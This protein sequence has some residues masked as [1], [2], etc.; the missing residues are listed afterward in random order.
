MIRAAVRRP[1]ATAMVFLGLVLIGAV[2]LG[3]I[4][5]DLL[6]E[7]NYPRLTA[8]TQY[9]DIQAE[10]VERLVTVPLEAAV[11]SLPSVRRVES[12]SREGL[13]V[14]TIEYEWGT[15]MDFAGLHLREA[16]DRVAFRTDFPEQ[17][18]RP[19]ILRWDPTSRPISILVLRGDKPLRE[20][21][22]FATE[23]AK[24]ALEQIQG[25]SQ[26]E[27]V[28]GLD[29]EI[30]IEPDPEK[31]RI[32]NLTI[33]DIV[34]ALQASNVSFPGGQVRSGPLHLSLRIIGEFEDL[35]QIAETAIER[36]GGRALRIG[37][38]AEVI[39]GVQEP[40]G[41]TILEGQDVV[42]FLLYK[43]IGA[44][45]IDV[46]DEIATVLALLEKQYPDFDYRFIYRDA[47]FIR[48]SFT[49]LLQSLLFGAFLAF[50]ILFLFLRDWRSPIVIGI[51]IPVSIMVT[52]AFLYL[53]NVKMNLMSLGG[54]SLAA[55]MLVDNAIVVLEN[56]TRHIQESA[57]Q[58]AHRVAPP[59]GSAAI[60]MGARGH[61][62]RGAGE[63]GG[64]VSAATLTTVAVFFPVVYVP[65]V[66]GEFF[67]DQALTVT[68]SLLVSVAAALLLQ[69]TLAARLLT[70]K[71][72]EPRGPF[73]LFARALSAVYRVYHGALEHALDH[74]TVWVIGLL[75]LL[76][77]SALVAWELPR[78]FL[79]ARS[80]GDLS[81]DIELPAGTPLEETK[82]T[83]V[84]IAERLEGLD[85][86]QTVFLEVGTTER[87]LA[88]VKEYT[89][90]HTAEIR[91]I[92]HPEHAGQREVEALKDR[93][94]SYLERFP[95]V[96]H[97]FRDEGIGLREIIGS[98]GAPFSLGILAEEA[99]TAVAAAAE[100]RAAISDVEG[101]VDLEVDRVLGTPNLVLR[102]DREEAIR[103]G[104]DPEFLARELRNRI[105]GVA[106]TT[107]NE[108]EQRV[109][110]AV[111]FPDA[112][113]KDLEG[114]LGTPVEVGPGRLVRLGRF[115]TLTEET[116][117]RE[118]VR[119][120]QRRL[121]TITG[122]VRGRRA[123]HVRRDAL[124]IAR[125][126]DLPPDVRF[127]EGGEQEEVRASFRELGF[128]LLLA[129][130][131]VYMILAGMFESFVDPLL[132]ASVLPMG[133]AGAALTLGIFGQSVNILSMIGLVALI[134][135]SV[136]DA[137]VKIHTIRR[138][139]TDEGYELR[140][141]VLEGS[142]LRFR[143][144][145]MTSVT[146][147]V[148]MVPMAIGLGSG[149]QLQRPLALTIIGGLALATVL[150]LIFTP[151]LYEWIHGR[152]E[153]R[154]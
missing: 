19:L 79:P 86:V 42:S 61:A 74:K 149:E 144:I 95:S 81:L 37:E 114:I 5:V 124:R 103:S 138:L 53:A 96:L 7:I 43:E 136:N 142:R 62:V 104:L 120:D 3:R 18:E 57:G 47:E 11:T 78:S 130:L 12:R 87:T 140:A 25:L 129:I 15:D 72:L 1:V 97:A 153:P 154:V 21:T 83:C 66:A 116:P 132:I 36:P 94:T 64:A 99:E 13:S 48:A 131:I 54:L 28:G 84:R 30:R 88:A 40:E 77:G 143:P 91:V 139:R 89:A 23:V 45:T 68:F 118:L 46:S 14:I 126:L 55:G 75:I 16:L 148:G 59:A 112:E 107:F 125:G 117:V 93:M 31:M 85:P 111:R 115:V 29:R 26:A 63:V 100:V 101:L 56:I 102:I 106:A 123:D 135:I 38:V 147:V 69:P 24:P 41:A 127:L 35:A 50:F 71:V 58:R 98:S 105:Q 67:R 92:L 113:R 33:S 133:V 17:A 4:P 70:V 109:D 49:G 134:G 22:E 108:A 20:I 52:F 8:V 32:Y 137:I 121:V 122:D 44:N 34:T 152:R 145:L 39:D 27:V 65:G 150:T 73:R 2:S 60:A 141:A 9:A 80:T 110:I 10:D 128:A 6:P 151:V 119:R 90:P 146:T 82:A 76:G 51:S